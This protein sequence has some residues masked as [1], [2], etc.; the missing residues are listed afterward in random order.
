MHFGEP[1]NVRYIRPIFPVMVVDFIKKC[2]GKPFA[3]DTTVMYKS[4]RKD[5]FQYLDSARRNGF[6]PETLGCPLIIAGGLRDNGVKVPVP[7]PIILPDITVCQEIWDADFLFSLAHMT[8]H[9]Q[10]PFAGAIKNISMGCV[11]QK[12]K[13]AMHNAKKYKPLHL[14]VQAAN[15]DGAK[16]ILEHFGNKFFA[17]NL[18]LD[19]TP[20]CD[21]FE[22]TDLPIVPDLGIFASSDP[23]ACDQASFDAVLN[24]TGYPNSMIEGTP[25]MFPGGDKVKGCHSAQTSYQPYFEFVRQAKIGNSEYNLV[26]I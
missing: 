7:Q 19:I 11:D 18:A 23:V 15:T 4:G 21:C 1:G 20:E 10:F 2:G 6:T 9:L 22:Q 25:A 17:V 16:V 24:S 5:Y 12:T 8:M 14:N 3:T 26:H 13:K